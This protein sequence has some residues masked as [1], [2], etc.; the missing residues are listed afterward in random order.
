MIGAGLLT[1]SP[2][3]ECARAQPSSYLAV[4]SSASGY[5]DSTML[6]KRGRAKMKK[7]ILCALVLAAN[8]VLVNSVLSQEK[9]P[10]YLVTYV[11]SQNPGPIR[12]ATAVTVTNQS[13][14]SCAVQV[15]W[16]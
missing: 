4:R 7:V 10:R 15:E 1:L 8:G 11:R 14:E 2:V 3:V 9:V 6:F 16:F 5:F 12:A 13:S